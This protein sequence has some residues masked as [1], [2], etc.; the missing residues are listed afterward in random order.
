[1]SR[2]TGRKRAA[3][4]P[5]IV[6]EMGKA[7]LEARE[8]LARHLATPQSFAV[9]LR[10]HGWTVDPEDLDLPRVRRVFQAMVEPPGLGRLVTAARASREADRAGPAAS[11]LDALQG[12]AAAVIHLGREAHWPA[13]FP[14]RH[15]A[16]WEEF[17][18][19]LL[20]ELIV[21]HFALHRPLDYAPLVLAGLFV[22]EIVDVRGTSGRSSYS[23][24]KV[25]WDRLRDEMRLPPPLAYT[26]ARGDER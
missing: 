6:I 24:R 20:D 13:P 23:R 9:L 11:V 10:R 5:E 19:E 4:R 15:P 17:P 3:L 7:L 12:V 1:V 18:R 21:D 2:R 16:F 8:P 26:P 25:R 22:E 14:F